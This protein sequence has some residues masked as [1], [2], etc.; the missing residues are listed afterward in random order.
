M[1][2]QRG[3]TPRGPLGMINIQNQIMGHLDNT[4]IAR[5]IASSGFVPEVSMTAD[6]TQ[7]SI[8]RLIA[9]LTLGVAS[10]ASVFSDRRR[11]MRRSASSGVTSQRNST[12]LLPVWSAT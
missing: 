8:E 7:G 12:R 10:D 6:G 4:P 5:A 9:S 1:P 3:A 11:T 2:G